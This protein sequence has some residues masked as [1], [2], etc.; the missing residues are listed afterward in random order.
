MPKNIIKVN[1]TNAIA[2]N[3]SAFIKLETNAILIVKYPKLKKIVKKFNFV[4]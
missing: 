4:S 3:K 2:R 1:V